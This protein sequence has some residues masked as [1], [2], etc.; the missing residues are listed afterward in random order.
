MIHLLDRFWHRLLKRPYKLAL[1]EDAGHGEQVVL[2]HGIAAKGAKWRPLIEALPKDK[3]RVV[4]PDLLGFGDSPKPD[5]LDYTVDQHA[6]TVLEFLKRQNARGPLTIV[7]HS[8][9]CL[10]AVHIAKLRPRLVKHLVLY[11]P[12]LLADAPEYPRYSRRKNRYVAFFGFLAQHPALAATHGHTLWRLAKKL[13]GFGLTEE[14]WTPFER[15]LRNTILQQ[16]VYNELHRL[17]I[18]TDIIYGRLDFVVIRT[19]VKRM[20]K[21]NKN[22]KLHLVNQPHDINARAAAYISKVIAGDVLP[23]HLQK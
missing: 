18:P 22:I 6:R 4:V 16:Q 20:F 2:L 1:A 13:A 19:E 17:K 15:S 7:G 3:Y 5:W 21:A 12:P 14:T 9:G 8:M 11:Q 23:R 10:V